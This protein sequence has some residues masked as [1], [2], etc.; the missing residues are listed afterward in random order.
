LQKIE[1]LYAVLK[2]CVS[3]GQVIS[4]AHPYGENYDSYTVSRELKR[5]ALAFTREQSSHDALSQYI[6]AM[7]IPGKWCGTLFNMILHWYK[8]I[9]EYMWLQLI[10]VL[11]TQ[12]LCLLQSVVDDV[13][14]L[15]Y[16]QQGDLGEHTYRRVSSTYID[17]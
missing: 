14:L 8:Q 13:I 16:M 12:T 1:Y 15:D 3:T 4:L 11:P 7:K 5:H 6:E 9:K 2:E 10:G 17:V